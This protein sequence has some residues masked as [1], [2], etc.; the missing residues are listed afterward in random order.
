MLSVLATI[1]LSILH[2]YVFGRF[3]DFNCMHVHM[4]SLHEHI[5][6]TC[7]PGAHGG[8]N[9]ASDLPKLELPVVVSHVEVL[10]IQPRTSRRAVTTLN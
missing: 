9:R 8:Q 3:T 7:M 10:G 6:N 5:R 2:S 1:V 4:F